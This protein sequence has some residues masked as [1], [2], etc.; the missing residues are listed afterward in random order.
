MKYLNIPFLVIFLLATVFM[1]GCGEEE[2][3][4]VNVITVYEQNQDGSQGA[5]LADV[6]VEFHMSEASFYSGGGVPVLDGSYSVYADKGYLS[7]W[8]SPHLASFNRVSSNTVLIEI[9]ENLFNYLIENND[10]K[11]DGVKIDGVDFGELIADCT[12]DNH[13]TFESSTDHIGFYITY[14][15]GDDICPEQGNVRMLCQ[16]H[17]INTVSLNPATGVIQN[18]V[19]SGTVLGQI[20]LFE[21]KENTLVMSSYIDPNIFELTF[22]LN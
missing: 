1:I 2:E 6:N 10:W 18:V 19:Q 21:F 20:G 13:L 7:N 22:V 15:E 16:I 9:R 17:D 4:V 8:A 14:D 11:L 3:P 5:P 12:W